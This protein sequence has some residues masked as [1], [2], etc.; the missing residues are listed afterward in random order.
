MENMIVCA[1]CVK[2][3]PMKD[4]DK[5]CYHV[6]FPGPVCRHHHGVQEEYDRLLGEALEKGKKIE[7]DVDKLLRDRRSRFIMSDDPDW[8]AMC[9]LDCGDKVM[10]PGD[11][12][13]EGCIGKS[14]DSPA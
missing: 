8:A 7:S 6:S 3:I 1:I 11:V 14:N 4:T 13:C 10:Y 2:E 12:V 5:W 9:C